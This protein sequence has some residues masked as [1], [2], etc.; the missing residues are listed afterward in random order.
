MKTSLK[1]IVLGAACGL[2]LSACA[3][4]YAG[5][6]AL[7]GALAGAAGTAVAGGD[8]ATGAAVGAA[9]GGAGGSLIKKNGNCYRV[10]NRGRERRV[11]CR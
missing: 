8:V 9:V 7:G 3:G 11:R 2:G 10:D 4:N 1:T 6:G 5:E